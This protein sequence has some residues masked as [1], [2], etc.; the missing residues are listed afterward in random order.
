MQIVASRIALQG[1]HS[2][3]VEQRRSEMLR[4]E[5]ARPAP[6]AV[7]APEPTSADP[8]AEQFA[9]EQEVLL[10]KMLVETLSGRKIN[11]ARI[12]TGEPQESAAPAMPT[13]PP[14][15]VEYSSSVFYRES[16]STSFQ[17]AGLVTTA[18]GTQIA[19]ALEL[20][21]SRSFESSISFGVSSGQRQDPLI[22]NL[23]GNA[24][25]L[26]SAKYSFDLDGDGRTEQI[27][28]ATGNSAFL[29]LD[30]NGNGRID[31][32]LELFGTRS[33]DGFSDLARHDSDAN[34]FIDQGDPVFSRLL[35]YARNSAG[36]ESTQSL[37]ELGIGALYLS[38]VETPFEL[39]DAGNQ[40][41]CTVR[42][43]G[44]FITENYASCTLQQV[45]L[46]V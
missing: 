15:S 2:T 18:D 46:A 27:S 34:G 13:A 25:Q 4:I 12:D 43:S 24:A 3:L 45:D 29:A 30:R 35:A 10:L 32:G 23:A 17:A 37:S 1:Q 22:L 31:N 8:A 7:A 6:P 21:M 16:E 20:T 39:R 26:S 36:E 5:R 11:V 42:S 33:G 40:T 14:L 28:F 19:L 44:L 41:L 38:R 9:L